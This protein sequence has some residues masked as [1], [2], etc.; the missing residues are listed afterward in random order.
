VLAVSVV[1]D[2]AVK[3]F[4]VEAVNVVGFVRSATFAF[5]APALVADHNS[6]VKLVPDAPA[7]FRSMP[8]R[9]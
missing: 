5:G 2:G 6:A 9:V 7:K 1:P 4:T 8:V 3:E